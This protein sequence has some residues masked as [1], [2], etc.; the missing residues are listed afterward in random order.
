LKKFGE[1]PKE[2]SENIKAPE[3]AP[4]DKRITGR[5]KSLALKITP[6]FHYDLK[7]LASEEKVFMTEIIEKAFAEYK[8]KAERKQQ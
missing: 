3:L 7:R 6:E 1:V 2:A 8:R 5:T 4:R